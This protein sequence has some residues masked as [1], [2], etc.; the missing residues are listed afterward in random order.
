MKRPQ[1]AHHLVSSE[2]GHEMDVL[3]STSKSW[4]WPHFEVDFVTSVS[5]EV[6][7]A[8]TIIG[9]TLFPIAYALILGVIQY[10]YD[11]GDPQKRS[12][13]NRLMSVLFVSMGLN[14]LFINITRVLRCWSGS[15]GHKWGIAFALLWRFLI[16][17]SGFLTIS[18]LGFKVLGHFKPSIV[19]GTKDDF[20]AVVILLIDLLFASIYPLVDWFT[21]ASDENPIIYYF[22]SGE[23]DIGS[24][25]TRQGGFVGIWI[26]V[27]LLL[28]LDMILKMVKK[29]PIEDAPEAP[30]QNQGFALNNLVHNPAIIS[31]LQTVVIVVIMLGSSLIKLIFKRSGL[32]IYVLAS[33]VGSLGVYLLV[34]ILIY[35]FNGKLRKYWYEKLPS[36]FKSNQVVPSSNE[37]ELTPIQRY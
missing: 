2:I 34:P 7:I 15:M 23:G 11:G 18:I 29:E 17:F 26:V 5:T 13:F 33:T 1:I 32:D 6:A 22:I 37:I 19:K 21:F 31:N 16:C 25:K 10:E 28:V 4:P 12:V 36:C 8:T 20:W 9:L 24:A 27:L 35:A 3:N 14:G 30:P